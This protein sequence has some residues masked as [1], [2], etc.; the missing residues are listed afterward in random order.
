MSHLIRTRRA[1]T[2]TPSPMATSSPTTTPTTAA[3]APAKMDHRPVNPVDL[4]GLPVPQAQALS[5]ASVLL[6]VSARRTYRCPRTTDQMSPLG[7]TTNAS[8]PTPEQHSALAHDI[9]HVVRTFCPML[10]KSWKAMPKETKNMVR[11]Q[12]ST[13]YN[14]EDMDKDMFAYL[15]RLFSECYKQWKSDLMFLAI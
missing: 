1:M 9:G 2:S 5:T 6:L 7:S 8:T 3:T 10:W 12:L 15:N 14:L 13:N 11:N 4:V